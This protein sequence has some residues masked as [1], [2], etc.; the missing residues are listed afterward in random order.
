MVAMLSRLRSR[1]IPWASLVPIALLAVVLTAMYHSFLTSLVR[2]WWL[3]ETYR[4]A[5]LI[6]VMS[7]YFVW[8][9][10]GHVLRQCGT[11]SWWAIPPAL[12]GVFAFMIG[13][14]VGE[15]LV[16]GLSLLLVLLGSLLSV[17]GTSL[18]RAAWFPVAFLGLS[19]P[20]PDG[21]LIAVL[22]DPLRDQTARWTAAILAGLGY[23]VHLEGTTLQLPRSTLEVAYECSGVK[24]LMASL[25]LAAAFAY[26]F[27]RAWWQRGLILLAAVPI[28]VISNLLRVVGIAARLYEWPAIP[29][30]ADIHGWTGWIPTLFILPSL[31]ATSKAAQWAERWLPSGSR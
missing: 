8:Q 27:H 3:T 31:V 7:G 29:A 22:G 28:G 17:G 12:G 18:F 13:L 24:G 9:E 26:I 16:T 10:R 1:P 5:F 20:I 15:P 11:P 23:S 2:Q 19:F 6:P 4:H 30:G 14:L 25:A 21:I